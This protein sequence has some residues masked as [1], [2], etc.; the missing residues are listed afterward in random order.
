M[1]GHTKHF[2]DPQWSF[3]GLLIWN[4]DCFGCCLGN[5]VDSPFKR[6]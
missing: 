1:L 4:H 5:Q 6:R 3:C 2:E